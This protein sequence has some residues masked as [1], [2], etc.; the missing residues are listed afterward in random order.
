MSPSPADDAAVPPEPPVI[1]HVSVRRPEDLDTVEE[2][3]AD[4]PGI[5]RLLDDEGKKTHHLDHPRAG[6]L[7]AVAKPDA[8][9]TYCYRLDDARAPDFAQLVE[10]HRKPGYDPVELFMDPLDPLVKV[11]AA[12]ALARKKLGLRYRTAVVPLDPSPIRRSH[13]SHGRLPAS[14]DDGPLLICSTPVLSTAASRPP[15]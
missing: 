12:T 7:V 14:D 9:F 3:L 8:W 10:I 6:E 15:M 4:L 2:A 1:A 11:K 5:E 13:G